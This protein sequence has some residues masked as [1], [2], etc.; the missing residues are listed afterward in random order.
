MTEQQIPKLHETL[1]W[2]VDNYGADAALIAPAGYASART[3][4]IFDVVEREPLREAEPVTF[5]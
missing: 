4:R 3:G 1:A 2:L 5:Q